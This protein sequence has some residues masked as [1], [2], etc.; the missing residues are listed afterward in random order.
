[1]NVGMMTKNV[2]KGETV[3]RIVLGLACIGLAFL[4]SGFFAWILGLVGVGLLLT[5]FFGY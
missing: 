4:L 1:M 3:L 5:A 2:G